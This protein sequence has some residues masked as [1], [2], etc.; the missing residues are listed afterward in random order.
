MELQMPD[1]SSTQA[2]TA[3]VYFPVTPSNTITFDIETGSLYVATGG[4]ITV[5][6]R[7]GTFCLF[8]NVPSGFILPVNCIG[9]RATGTA[10]SGI[11]AMA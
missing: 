6:R 8:P 3:T 4:D 2:R 10:A 1:A 9:V 5:V 11:V 7:N